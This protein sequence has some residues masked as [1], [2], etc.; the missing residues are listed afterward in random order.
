[1]EIDRIAYGRIN[2]FLRSDDKRDK[3]FTPQEIAEA[4]GL[5]VERIESTIKKI[6]EDERLFAGGPSVV[7]GEKDGY[8][9]SRTKYLDEFQTI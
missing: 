3:E 7:E 2:K 5:S 9:R 1:M 4:T 6:L 8:Y